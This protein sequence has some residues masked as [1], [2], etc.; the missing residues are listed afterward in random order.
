M[1]HLDN[2]FKE[3]WV[4][5]DTDIH[6]RMGAL[7]RSLH[8]RNTLPWGELD[9]VRLPPRFLTNMKVTYQRRRRLKHPHVN[10]SDEYTVYLFQNRTYTRDYCLAFCVQLYVSKSCGCVDYNIWT[11]K[12]VFFFLHILIFSDVRMTVIW[13]SYCVFS[14]VLA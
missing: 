2:N 3:H 6:N 9:G 8:L 10:W 12:N 7:Q 11:R 5:F 14:D 1:L 4:Y 13:F